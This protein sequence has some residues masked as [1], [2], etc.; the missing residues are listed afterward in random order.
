[1]LLEEE[2][3]VWEPGDE[4]WETKLAALRSYHRAHSH[5]A[6][7]QTTV[8]DGQPIGQH[9]ANLR[10]KGGLG[11]DPV[12]AEARAGDLAAIDEDWNSPWPLDW[13]RCYAILRDLATTEPHGTLPHIQPG[14]TY[15]GD[16]LGQWIARQQRD[17]T[18]L[19]TDQQERLTGLGIKPAERPSPAPAARGAAKGPGKT[20]AAFTRGMA[21]LAQYVAREGKTS[22]PRGHSEEITAEGEDKPVS[23]RLG[24]F[25]SNT[26]SRRDKLTA[27][28]RAALA[29]LGIDWA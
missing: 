26:K 25:L 22:V 3:M 17:W 13:Q 2:G 14:V 21:A 7:K 23:V 29:E 1:V 11:K 18:Q 15:E 27:P 5:L 4:A 28:Q 19:N 10:R 16:D 6:P 9:M 20:S 24:V 12:R 8:W